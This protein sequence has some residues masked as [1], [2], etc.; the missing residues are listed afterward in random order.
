MSLHATD[1]LFNHRL[2]SWLVWI[3]LVLA[4]AGA[5]CG[6]IGHY[7]YDSQWGPPVEVS[8]I[9]YHTLQL[10]VLHSPHMEHPVSPWLHVGRWL[11]SGAMFILIGYGLYRVFRAEW[12]LVLAPWRRGHVVI[13]G[14]GRLGLQL[15]DE[16]RRDRRTVVA[17]EADAS[18]ETAARAADAGYAVI[19]GDARSIKDLDRAA[20][21]RAKQVIA[22]C[23]DEQTNVAIAAAV[24]EL[25]QSPKVRR[26]EAEASSVRSLLPIR[27]SARLFKLNVTRFFRMS[28]RISRSTCEA[29]TCSSSPARNAFKNYPLD[30]PQIGEYDPTRVHLIIVGFGPT[31]RNLALQAAK[32][33]HFANFKKLKITV[34]ESKENPTFAAF[35]QQYPKFE[36]I[37]D[38]RSAS[39]SLNNGDFEKNLKQL[40]PPPRRQKS[41]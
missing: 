8:S 18:V 34:V 17:I 27:R 22:V 7:K 10:F 6:L 9:A 31:G 4:I 36:E 13:C 24:G 40:L 1:Q 38:L 23:D 25:M 35:K 12:L 21:G 32:I 37:R 41:W 15:A 39:L 14:L 3:P 20:V 28:A 33:G 19:T 26:T 29:W 30:L 11:V 5:I 16:F 2:R